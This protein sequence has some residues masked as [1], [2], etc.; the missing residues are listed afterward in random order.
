VNIRGAS[1]APG[2]A[3]IQWPCGTANNEK[4]TVTVVDG[5]QQFAARHSGLC[6][7]QADTAATGG[8]VV[9]VA[10]TAGTTTHWLRQGNVLRNRASGACLDV[11]NFSTTADTQLVTWSCNGGA[12]QGWTLSP[13]A[14]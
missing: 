8:P 4:F 11:P 1:S 13:I 14:P 12:N 2:A 9:Q 3:V 10:C 5:H 6:I 7:A